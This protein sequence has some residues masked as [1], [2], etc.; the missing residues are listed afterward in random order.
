VNDTFG[1]DIGDQVLRM[2]AN[3]LQHNLRSM[4]YVGRWGGEE[5]VAIVRNVNPARLYKVAAKLC[6]LVRQ[7]RFNHQGKQIRVTVSVGGAC[8]QPDDNVESLLKRADSLLY[9]SKGKGRNQVSI[10][11]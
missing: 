4:D 5:F 8:A 9:Q 6:A 1:H 7:S 11:D 2:V 10:S 3:T